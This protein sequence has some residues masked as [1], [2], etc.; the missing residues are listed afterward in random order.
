MK[1]LFSVLF[2]LITAT[3]GAVDRFKIIWVDEHEISNKTEKFN[4]EIENEVANQNRLG[5]HLVEVKHFRWTDGKSENPS[6]SDAV[7]LRFHK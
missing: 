4:Q 2:L 5:F 7:S 1:L 3:A 6:E